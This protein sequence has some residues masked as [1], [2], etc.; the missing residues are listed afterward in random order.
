MLSVAKVMCVVPVVDEWMS[1]NR[2]KN[3]T[4]RKQAI[5]NVAMNV[6]VL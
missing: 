5:V 2:C 3:D 1:V 6:I 4:D